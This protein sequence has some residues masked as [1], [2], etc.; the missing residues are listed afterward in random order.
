MAPDSLIGFHA[1]WTDENGQAVTSGAGNALAGAYMAEIGFS[2]QA[3][4]FATTAG[5]DGMTWLSPASADELG[6]AVHVVNPDGT[7]ATATQQPLQLPKGYR[8]IVLASAKTADALP[9]RLRKG[10]G[11]F[12]SLIVQ[13]SNG[14]VAAVVGPFTQADAGAI[15]QTGDAPADAFLSSGRGF[16]VELPGSPNP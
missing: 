14:N 12:R 6:I 4:I 15:I 5:P 2:D 10:L 16:V 1:A 7:E 13:T 3:I 8:W 11:Q 9:P